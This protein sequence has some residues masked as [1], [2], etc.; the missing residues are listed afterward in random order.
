M[1]MRIVHLAIVSTRFIVYTSIVLL[2]VRG[3]STEYVKEFAWDMIWEMIPLSIV[4][5]LTCAMVEN[6]GYFQLDFT[7]ATRD[8]FSEMCVFFGGV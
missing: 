7:Y 5:L 2:N 4:S 6:Y 1:I 8:D 3:L